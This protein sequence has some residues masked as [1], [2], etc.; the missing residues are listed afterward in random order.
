MN[1]WAGDTPGPMVLPGTYT[2]RLNVN[3]QAQT[4]T[5]TV[6]ADPRSE[7]TAA[8]NVAKF[9]MLQKIVARVSEAN[10]GV[11]TIRNVKAQITQR[12][13]ALPADRRGEFERLSSPIVESLTSIEGKLYQLRGRGMP[14][15]STTSSRGWPTSSTK[16]RAVRRHRSRQCTMFSSHSSRHW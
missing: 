16:L 7:A 10:N 6:E 5:L 14:V 12:S 2:V 13:S 4:E 9:E 3:G 1:T 8:D 11:R 15:R